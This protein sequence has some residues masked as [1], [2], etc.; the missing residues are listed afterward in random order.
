MLVRLLDE[1]GD[2]G[3]CW[4]LSGA[5]IQA[6]WYVTQSQDRKHSTWASQGQETGPG[7]C[8][9]DVSAELALGL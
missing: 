4:N 7:G 3:P 1:C 5:G 6:R 2:F 9:W 8:C